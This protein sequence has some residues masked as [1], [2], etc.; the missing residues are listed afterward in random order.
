MNS[1]LL[2]VEEIL[3]RKTNGYT[4]EEFSQIIIS[5]AMKAVDHFMDTGQANT[6]NC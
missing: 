4:T 6:K 2:V 1:M 5:E 3:K